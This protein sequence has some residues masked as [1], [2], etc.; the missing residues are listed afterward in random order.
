MSMKY[1]NLIIGAAT[2]Y[3]KSDLFNFVESLRKVYFEKII[4][5]MNNTI[6]EE[7][8]HYLN[9]KKI[10][11]YFTNSTSRT[12]FKDRYKIYL[13]IIK[14]QYNS[15]NVMV[16]DTKDVIF[17]ENPFENLLFS[18]L[19]FFL[20]DKIIGACK[21]NSRWITRSY[22]VKNYNVIKNK[23][24]S[25]SGVTLGE[26]DNMIT[27]CDNMVKEIKNFKYYSLNPFNK[28]SDQ[29]NH[30]NLVHSKTYLFE[31]KF[32]NED[33]FVVNLSNSDPEII[34]FKENNFYI[35]KKKVSVLHQYNSHKRVHNEVK[36]YIKHITQ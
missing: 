30:N 27:Y 28:G 5:I 16:S 32:T 6:D 26:K 13:D 17:L 4:L 31:K 12:I 10:D 23:K 9:F 34:E 33:C 36:S 14:N 22:G 24:I 20:E 35:N 15:K 25:C 11:I 3:K 2:S 18:K 7:T 19:N 21:T 1:E 29:G 8:N